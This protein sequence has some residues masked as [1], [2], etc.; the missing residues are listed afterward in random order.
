MNRWDQTHMGWLT[1]GSLKILKGILFEG[2][3]W[4]FLD[5]KW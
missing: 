1:C 5:D 3:V 2:W 4:F